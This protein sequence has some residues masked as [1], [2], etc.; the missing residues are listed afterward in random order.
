MCAEIHIAVWILLKEIYIFIYYIKIDIPRYNTCRVSIGKDFP[1]SFT[2]VSFQMKFIST[3]SPGN[4]M[5]FH[6]ININ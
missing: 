4:Y 2:I 3:N 5:L 1:I 6:G